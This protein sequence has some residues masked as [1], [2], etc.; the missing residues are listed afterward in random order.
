MN[1]LF[2]KLKDIDLTDVPFKKGKFISMSIKESKPSFNDFDSSEIGPLYSF[3]FPDSIGPN[4]WR[5]IK[6]K[7]NNPHVIKYIKD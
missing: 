6:D 4:Q 1:I 5:M 7:N 3:I 2:P